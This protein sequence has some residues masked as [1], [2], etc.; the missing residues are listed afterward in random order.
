MTMLHLPHRRGPIHG[1]LES[2]HHPAWRDLAGMPIALHLGDPAVESQTAKKGALCDVSALPRVT[3]KGPGA[4]WLLGEQGI[5]MPDTIYGAT[6]LGSAGVAAR[7]GSAEF[8]LEDGPAGNDV[9]RLRAITGAFGHARPGVHPVNRAD[10]SF[11]LSGTGA[12]DVLEQTCGYSFRERD[13]GT[14]VF[15]RIAGVSC[16]ILPRTLNSIDLFQLWLDGTYG[17][18]L[19]ETLLDVLSASEGGAVGAACYFPDL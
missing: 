19:W 6:P 9:A 13:P 3:L 15:T 4:L 18:Y 11:L 2:H 17:E 16:S 5:A 14:M 1:L 12:I 8:F 7:T 10:A